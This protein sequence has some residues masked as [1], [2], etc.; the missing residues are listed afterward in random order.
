MILLLLLTQLAGAD[1]DRTQAPKGKNKCSLCYVAKGK[2]NF[3]NPWKSSY[4]LT[5]KEKTAS[6]LNS[7]MCKYL[8]QES[9]KKTAL[10][11]QDKDIKT[12]AIYQSISKIYSALGTS[13]TNNSESLE[14]RATGCYDVGPFSPKNLSNGVELYFAKMLN[15]CMARSGGDFK[16]SY[17]IDITKGKRDYSFLKKGL[18]GLLRKATIIEQSEA[19]AWI[20]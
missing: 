13:N 20:N 1:C 12:E 16:K 18:I 2:T 15:S 6:A 5:E 9:F 3:G 7:V 19:R 10:P 14:E 17:C 11:S 4:T 8:D